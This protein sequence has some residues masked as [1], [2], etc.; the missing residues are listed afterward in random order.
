MFAI[1][2]SKMFSDLQYKNMGGC[3][4]HTNAAQMGGHVLINHAIIRPDYIQQ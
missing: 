2:W 3:G 4:P 1:S